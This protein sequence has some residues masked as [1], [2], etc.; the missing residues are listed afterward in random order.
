MELPKSLKIFLSELSGEN[1]PSLHKFDSSIHESAVKDNPKLL[2]LSVTDNSRW[3]KELS[4]ILMWRAFLALLPAEVLEKPD[5]PCK[6]IV[7]NRLHHLLGEDPD[8][9]DLELVMKIVLR[10]RL[11]VSGGRG[12]IGA[13]SFDIDKS[14]HFKILKRQNFRCHACGYR[15]KEADLDSNEDSNIEDSETQDTCI[16]TPVSCFDRSPLKLHRSAVLDHIY[17]IYLGGNSEKN[18]Q[19]LC[20]TCN[21]GKQ[22]LLLGYEGKNWFGSARITDLTLVTPQLFYMVLNRDQECKVCSRKSTQAELRIKRKDQNGA[23]LYPNLVACCVED[24]PCK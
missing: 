16:S 6:D 23:D 14:S 7:K 17:P 12:L 20:K 18:W 1:A 5:D 24:I 13:S 9:E 19:V 11:Y 22:D 21:S 8:Q 15:F 3:K 10:I 2:L 4:L